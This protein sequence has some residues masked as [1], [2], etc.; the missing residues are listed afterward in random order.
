MDEHLPGRTQNTSNSLEVPYRSI[1]LAAEK[2]KDGL[3]GGI[4]VRPAPR[5][6]AFSVATCETKL[7]CGRRR[8][9]RRDGRTGNDL[10]TRWRRPLRCTS[11]GA[12]HRL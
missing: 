8:A 6:A 11:G 5:S 4:L 2:S 7:P 10:G 9:P 12:A 1:L 3:G